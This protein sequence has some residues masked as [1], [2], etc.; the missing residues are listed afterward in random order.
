MPSGRLRY[1]FYG[2]LCLCGIACVVFA[3]Q[4]QR[5]TRFLAAGNQAVM[6]KRFDSQD[7]T[8]ARHIWFA[9]QDML[10]FNQ[11]VLAHTAGNLSRA[12]TSFRQVSHHASSADLRMQAL[13]NLGVVL[14]Q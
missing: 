6:E 9:S 3:F 14:L 10:L 7:Y 13:Y 12:T 2:L 4:Q 8:R 1:L 11:G 5:Y